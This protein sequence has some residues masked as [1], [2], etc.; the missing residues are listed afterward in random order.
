SVPHR[1]LRRERTH[2]A[3]G[4][5][6][7]GFAPVLSGDGV[8]DFLRRNVAVSLGLIAHKRDPAVP[9]HLDPCNDVL[10][11]RA[12]ESDRNR[13]LFDARNSVGRASALIFS[14]IFA[15]Y[16]RSSTII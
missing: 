2:A 10:R 11:L 7:P 15:A 4:Y 14:A 3:S 9:D 16:S 1:A 12:S 6:R 5:P 8:P 13:T